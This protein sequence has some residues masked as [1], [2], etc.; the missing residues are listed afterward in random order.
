MKK[1]SI[2]TVTWYGLLALVFLLALLPILRSMTSS[3][4]SFRDLDCQGVTCPEGEFCA[5]GKR[6][7]KIATRYPNNVPTGDM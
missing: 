5:E 2:K 4:D 6:C 1:F 3:Y 7:L